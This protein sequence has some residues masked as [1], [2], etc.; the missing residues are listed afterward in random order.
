M[1]A[2]L[3]NAIL[4]VSSAEDSGGGEL[5]LLDAIAA[6][7][8]RGVH[9]EVLNIVP[10]S[11]E[12]AQTLRSRGIEVHHCPIG[13]FRDPLSALRVLR[14]FLSRRSMFEL[15]IANDARALLY[16]ALGCRITRCPYVWYVHDLIRGV[17][18]FERAAARLGA[19][20]VIAVSRAVKRGLESLGLL[21]AC[22]SVVP[23][24]IDVDR[25]HPSVDGSAVRRE[26]GVPPEAL[27]IGAVGRI[28]PLKGLEFLV[29]AAALLQTT[30][31][32][33]L[34]IVVGDVVTDRFH[35]A[36]ARAYRDRL[37]ALR[38]GLGLSRQVRF[39]GA[40][41]DLPAV[42][43]ALDILAHP[44][45][46]EAFGRVLIEAM[47]A[48]RPVVASAVGGMPEIVE[49][50]VTGY[51]VPPSDPEAL[52]S[53]IFSLANPNVRRCVGRAARERAVNAFALPAFETRLYA[54]LSQAQPRLDRRATA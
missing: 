30:L 8:R 22:I 24:A 14:W 41:R 43:A 38:D 27:V 15:A 12:L 45:L 16:T 4:W 28:L 50:G 37:H 18:P 7:G 51:L 29:E 33:A 17:S 36:E 1:S 6:L 20:R 26:L 34:Y 46:E 23:N 32:Q 35:Q 11:G 39:V 21:S 5:V 3:G 48:G 44:S 10:A 19:T 49:D 42:M 52:A 47:A 9:C 54:A 13:R 40:R 2:A 31:P 25:F 53:R